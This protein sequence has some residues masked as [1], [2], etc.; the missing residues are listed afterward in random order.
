MLIKILSLFTTITALVGCTTNAPDI[1]TMCL[2]DDIG[3]YIIKWETYPQMQGTVKMYVSDNPDTFNL[4]SPAVYANIHDGVATYITNDNISRK[5]F[6]L[7][8]NDKYFQTVGG[9]SV[10][11]DSVQNLRDLGGYLGENEQVTRWGRIFRSGQLSALSEWDTIRLDNLKIKTIVDLRTDEEMTMA[12]I[13]YTKAQVIRIPVA[14]GDFTG[15]PERIVKGEMRKGDGILFMQ[16]LYLQYITENSAPFAKAL[17]P[18]LK[19]ENYPILFNCTL[20]KDRAGFL[21]AMLLAALD[22][23]EETIIKDYA[24]SEQYINLEHLAYLAQG[25]NTDAQET[26]TV[27]LS[28]NEAY[29]DLVFHKIKRDYGSVHKYLAKEMHLTEKKQE[30]LKDMMLY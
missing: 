26:I 14:V 23:P 27:L 6:Q 29:M 1:R 4:A 28:S 10:I 3:N 18:F 17:E 22:V 25:L 20:G 2:R 24:L 19:P 30:K 13:R 21:A 12:P 11:M 7:S 5:Y 15:I 9:R 8:F 16:D